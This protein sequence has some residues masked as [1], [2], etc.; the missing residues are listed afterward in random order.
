[1]YCPPSHD[2]SSTSLKAILPYKKRF[3]S[4]AIK[5][6]GYNKCVKDDPTAPTYLRDEFRIPSDTVVLWPLS[7]AVVQ[8]A[9][10]QTYLSEDGEVPFY[11]QLSKDLAG[12]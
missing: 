5:D 4:L 11:Q 8:A 12:W 1:M 9:A 6:A 3:R 2:F 10:A 7:A